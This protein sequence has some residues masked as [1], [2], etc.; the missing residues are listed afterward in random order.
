MS[1]IKRAKMQIKQRERLN[2][3]IAFAEHKKE[4]K[5]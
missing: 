5:I 4:T 3:I 1:D 2:Q